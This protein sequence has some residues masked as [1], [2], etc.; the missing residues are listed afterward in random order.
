M[1]SPSAQARIIRFARAV[2]LEKKTYDDDG[3]ACNFYKISE[4]FGLKLGRHN[5]GD[6][7]REYMGNVYQKQLQA[8]QLPGKLG[9][10]CF[11]FGKYDYI[12][13]KGVRDW[14]WGYITE[15]VPIHYEVIGEIKYQED[16]YNHPQ[17][18]HMIRVFGTKLNPS[19][20]FEDCHNQN[21]GIRGKK[22]VCID[23]GDD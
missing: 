13:Y 2:V 1:L 9:P 12:N 16:M 22:M 21:I 10:Y 20:H 18:K 17:I 3:V 6:D 7:A 23:F 14:S 8:S 11:G 19:F 15:I 5:E 4:N